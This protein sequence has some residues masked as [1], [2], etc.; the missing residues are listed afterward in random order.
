MVNRSR[1]G[2]ANYLSNQGKLADDPFV[3]LPYG[4]V[5]AK[6]FILRQQLM[7]KYGLLGLIDKHN[8][9]YQAE[10]GWRGGQGEDWEKGP[11]YLRGLV[12]LAYTLDDPELKAKAREWI[13]AIISLQRENGFF[14]PLSL[15]DGTEMDRFDWWPAMVVVQLMRDYYLATEYEG[16]PDERA[17]RFLEKYF[18]YQY[19]NLDKEK[20]DYWASARGADNIEVILWFYN[21][22][23]NPDAPGDNEWL[24]ELAQK[25]RPMVF[26]WTQI[27][28][29]TGIRHHVVNIEQGLKYPAVVYQMSKDARD[30]NAFKK[31]LENINITQ[32]RADTLPNADEFS[33]DILPWHG[34]ELCA[35]AEGLLSSEITMRILGEAW[36]G[37]RMERL[38]YNALPAMYPPDQSGHAYF[39]A[40]NQVMMIHGYHGFIH[41][42]GDNNTF[43]APSGFECCLGNNGMGFSKFVQTMWMATLDNGLAVIAYGPNTV[44]ARVC[45]GKTAVFDQSTNYPFDENIRLTY[46]GE[47]AEFPL[48][49]KIPHW[50]ENPQL[51]LCGKKVEAKPVNGFIRIERLWEYGDTLQ[52][53]LPM[54]VRIEKRCNAAVS[55]ER[56]P[57][58]YSLRIKED[59]RKTDDNDCRH[60][61][62]PPNEDFPLHEIYPAGPWNYGLIFDESDIE[63]SFNVQVAEEIP[64]QPYTSDNPPVVIRARGQ[65]IPSWKLLYNSVPEL[66]FGTVEFNPDMPVEDIELIPAACARLK[67][68]QIPVIQSAENT[69]V[70]TDARITA[71]SGMNAYEFTNLSVPYSVDYDLKVGYCGA[72]CCK[73][74]INGIDLGDIRL[75]PDESSK[76]ITGLKGL[77]T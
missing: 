7:Q 45:S 75:T 25:M 77:I 74:I 36:I 20:F 44:R 3:I 62:V 28:S 41:D 29:E 27:Y 60:Y 35:V 9:H 71:E 59:W 33:R 51:N 65:R 64:L 32:G 48:L 22:S 31:G 55:V 47:T 10:S 38:A 53:V 68:T 56:G 49:L 13:D 21:F 23:F 26:D 24:L 42:Y 50:C 70:R 54:R 14:G 18:R 61:D 15:G 11:Y 39:M 63:K 17:V 34:T 4:A 57:L 30:R 52:L 37:D 1:R 72:G 12:A 43:S 40:Q 6:D 66:P 67:I 46:S 8:V 5:K 2:N 76:T 19:E 69:I 73:L 58:I 16:H